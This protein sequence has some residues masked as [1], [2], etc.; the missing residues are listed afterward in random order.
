MVALGEA[1]NA[2]QRLLESLGAV[3]DREREICALARRLGA[4]GAKITGAGG[5]GAVAMLHEDPLLLCRRINDRGLLA[6][7]TRPSEV[8]A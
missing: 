7:P 3:D 2:N 6:I 5:G 8:H 1:M 4:R